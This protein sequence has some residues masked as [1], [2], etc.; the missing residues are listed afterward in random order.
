MLDLA[1]G[2]VSLTALL[3][4]VNRRFVG[5]PPTIGVMAIALVCSL[6]L[7]GLTLLGLPGLEQRIQTAM[8]RVDFDRLLLDCLLSFLLFAG[9]MNLDFADIRKRAW[10][11]GLLATAGVAIS[12]LGIGLTTWWLLQQLDLGVSLVWCL[13]FGAIV[14]PTDPVAVL[15]IL[16]SAGAPKS[17]ETT[18]V[19]E[20]LFN[21]GMAVV[22]FTLLVGTL[23]SEA[24]PALGETLWLLFE[25]IGGGLLLGALLGAL[26]YRLMNSIDDYQVEVLL[27]VALVLGGYTWSTHLEISGPIAMTVAGL[28][29][30]NLVR[31]R[32]LSDRTRKHLDSFWT[33]IDEFL[34]ALL[35]VLM[36][37]ELV[38]V[39]FEWRYVPLALALVAVILGVRLATVG[40]PL[41]LIGFWKRELPTGAARIL[42]WG[43][44][45][46]GVSVAL[47]LALP[48][49]EER[50]LLLN[51]TYLVVLF[52]VLVQGL[53]IGRLVQRA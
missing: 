52:S 9:A 8:A 40:P 4:F 12:I 14:A 18:I 1:A 25:E 24:P 42:T 36:G 32:A 53:T 33:L 15:G 41:A 49:G 48:A 46:G 51:L 17:L 22:A 47:V 50:D 11:I 19:G 23:G 10:A 44:L 34:N 16:K 43:G 6:L 39:P 13:V 38:L 5:L 29:V 26:A 45:R 7:H 28:I 35:F 20:S 2:F 31:E 30:G 21:D 3:A 37:L 27:T